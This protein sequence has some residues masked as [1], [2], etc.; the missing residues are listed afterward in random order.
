[1]WKKTLDFSIHYKC[2]F[3]ACKLNKQKR[4]CFFNGHG[5]SVLCPVWVFY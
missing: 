2:F 5:A 3:T 1:M 4:V